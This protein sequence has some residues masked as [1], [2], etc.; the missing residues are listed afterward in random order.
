MLKRRL[1]Q[2]GKID[3]GIHIEGKRKALRRRLSPAGDDGEEMIRHERE[4]ENVLI[5]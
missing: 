3:V 4:G 1:L 5:S 2:R